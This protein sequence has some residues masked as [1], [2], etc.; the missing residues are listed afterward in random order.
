MDSQLLLPPPPCQ[1]TLSF[2][3]TRRIDAAR[4]GPVTQ[5]ERMRLAR[6]VIP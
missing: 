3:H 1:T 4:P 2:Y 6:P 5:P